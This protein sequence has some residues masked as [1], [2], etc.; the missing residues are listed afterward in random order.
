[1]NK[2]KEKEFFKKHYFL[3]FAFVAMLLPHILTKLA[4]PLRLFEDILPL[5]RVAAGV[6]S[7][8]WIFIFIFVC[9][10]FLNKKWGRIT[11]GVTSTVFTVLSL[12]Q[13][14]YYGI[15][16]QF[17]WL[18]SIALVGEGGEY[19]SYALDYLDAKSVICTLSSAA[20]IVIASLSWHKIDFRHKWLNG[21]IIVPIAVISVFHGIFV[22]SVL[23][24]SDD[25]NSWSKP[26]VIYKNFT[27]VN[28]DMSLSGLYQHSIRDLWNTVFPDEG[29]SKEEYSEV[30][31]YFAENVKNSSENEY[32]DIFKGKNVIAVMLE[33]VDTWMIDKKHT[34]TMYKMKNEGISFEN[35]YSPFFGT[36][37][38]LN[39]EFAFNTGFFSP[40]SAVSAVNFCSNSFPDSLAN[41]FSE[42][43]YTANSFHYNDSEFYNRG[44]M[45]HSFGYEKYNSFSDFGMPET[46][47]QSDS[48]ILKNDDIYNKM[49]GEKPFF[50]FVITYSTH[51]P[52]LFDDS[53][54]ILARENHSNLINPSMDKET[55]NCLILA[56]DTD[57]FFKQLLD[58]LEADGLLDDTV[59][60]A[61]T[62]HYA[63][64]FSD[65]EKLKKLKKNEIIYRVPAFIYAKGIKPEKIKKPM[66]TIDWV[67]TLINMFGLENRGSYLGRDIFD[68]ENGGFVYFGDQS[69]L[70][71]KMHFLPLEDTPQNA[72]LEYIKQ[73]NSKVKQ[74]ININEIVIN[75][76]F[77]AAN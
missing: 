22:S 48:N 43:G 63:Y 30:E 39:A 38:T 18:K 25:W 62:D 16:G 15:F 68:P 12:C 7:F 40:L 53:K 65:E 11:F 3:F 61:Y 1:M 6:F 77:F 59:I 32:T 44:V 67:P 34:P 2:I 60:L 58:R 31:N 23:G 10:V 17:F 27:D 74:R 47:S 35:Y 73:Q 21:F 46:V 26:W 49:V 14:V 9:S 33:G 45:H 50:N 24:L 76:D 4:L 13:Y 72:D 57:D 29:F 36:G 19:L 66:S 54:L 56:A 55:N 8:C 69:W 5:S 70:D 75:G 41:L 64:G 71:D 37:H 28:K 52:Y 20:A 51:V 42:A